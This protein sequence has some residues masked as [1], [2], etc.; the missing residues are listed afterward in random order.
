M[1]HLIAI[2]ATVIGTGCYSQAYPS[3]NLDLQSSTQAPQIPLVPALASE[4][5]GA[6]Y[7]TAD[8]IPQIDNTQVCLHVT[9]DGAYELTTEYLWERGD[10]G[11]LPAL[12]PIPGTIAFYPADNTDLVLSVTGDAYT[13]K[14][15]HRGDDMV[16]QTPTE[17][18]TLNLIGYGK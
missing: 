16:L 3:S 6:T 8:N 17:T 12:G 2:L 4:L 1:R 9:D 10:C 11:S 5:A 7:C 15:F 18:F 14:A 13:V